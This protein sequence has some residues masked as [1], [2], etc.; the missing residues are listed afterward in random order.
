MGCLTLYFQLYIYY[1]KEGLDTFDDANVDYLLTAKLNQEAVHISVAKKCRLLWTCTGF[2]F[3]RVETN[4]GSVFQASIYKHKLILKCI[5]GGRDKNVSTCSIMNIYYKCVCIIRFI[6]SKFRSTTQNHS[7][8]CRGDFHAL[9]ETPCFG[10]NPSEYFFLS[11][12]VN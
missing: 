7:F 11:Q 8:N 9:V 10:I 1:G 12:K 6:F 5:K 4:G 3:N 2:V